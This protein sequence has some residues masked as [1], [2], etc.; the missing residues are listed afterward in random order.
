[1]LWEGC[2]DLS[3]PSFVNRQTRYLLIYIQKYRNTHTEYQKAI[4]VSVGRNDSWSCEDSGYY[5]NSTLKAFQAD[6][7]CLEVVEAAP[8]IPMRF[9]SH[10][11]CFGFLCGPVFPFARID[12]R[13][14]GV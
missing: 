11:E 9:K 2:A 6:R 8:G 14:R 5:K 13:A 10:Q 3:I 7:A 1:V 4:F 12:G